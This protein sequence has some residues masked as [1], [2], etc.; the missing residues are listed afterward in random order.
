MKSYRFFL[1]NLSYVFPALLCFI[2]TNVLAQSFMPSF[3]AP[4]KQN[5]LTS[6]KRS[7]SQNKDAPNESRRQGTYQFDGFI[8][9]PVYQNENSTFGLTAKTQQL[10]FDNLEKNSNFEP[11]PDL[12]NHQYGLTWAHQTDENTSWSFGG[13]YGSASNKPFEGTDVTA[14]DTTL[15]KSE[16][17]SE[18][19]S[20]L[21]FVNYSNN[22]ALLNNI[23][24]PG[25]AYVFKNV[26][27]T[28]GGAIGL[29]FFSYWWMP[30][31]KLF[32]SIFV[33]LPSNAQWQAGYLLW[34]PFQALVK[35]E[36]G[37]QV[38]MRS[39][40]QRSE[41]RIF[42]DVKKAATSI[43]TYLGAST[44]LEIEVAKIFDRYLYDGKSNIELRSDRMHLPDDTQTT[45]SFQ[46]SF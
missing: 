31:P 4:G 43:K 22:R 45:F 19:A 35:L 39:N 33:M 24:I 37:Q 40:R 46:I 15:T 28:R 21:Y 7:D 8:F 9:A 20:W 30:T 36:Y 25:F 42:Y 18:T 3:G 2:S 6:A 27:K 12:Y 34:G 5:F 26:E 41:D 29:P 23:P 38:Y 1:R 13:I 17:I 14:I 32:T 10:H 44:Y 11:T 16:K